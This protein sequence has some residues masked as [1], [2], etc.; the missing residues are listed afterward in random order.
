MLLFYRFLVISNTKESTVIFINGCFWH[1]H[2]G[3]KYF[4]WPKSN[5]CF[6]EEKIRSNVARDIKQQNELE[7]LGWNIIIV[8]ECELK[9]DKL[10]Q[11][12]EHLTSLL[13]SSLD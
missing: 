12:M 6:W 9:R 1:M 8:W 7:N 11:T 10:E 4:V 5:I 2:K 13:K 3:C